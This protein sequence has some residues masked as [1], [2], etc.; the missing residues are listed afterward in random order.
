MRPVQS[1]RVTN[2]LR[3]DCQNERREPTEGEQKG[4]VRDRWVVKVTRLTIKLYDTHPVVFKV[5]KVGVYKTG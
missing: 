3:G 5:Q 1:E 2:F 4:G